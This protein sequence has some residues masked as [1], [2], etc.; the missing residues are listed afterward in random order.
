MT[1]REW[2]CGGGKKLDNLL[3]TL[4]SNFESQVHWFPHGDQDNIIFGVSLLSTW[5]H[6]T[7]PAGRQTQMTNWV[8]WVRDLWRDSDPYLEDFA[9]FSQVMQKMSGDMDWKLNAAV[10]CMTDSLPGANELVRVYVDWVQ[11]NWRAAGLRLQDDRN[12]YEIAWSRLW[13]RLKIKIHTFTPKNGMFDRI[14]ELSD[15]A[16][17][18]EVMS[19]IL[20]MSWRSSP[21]SARGISSITVVARS[22]LF[23]RG[24]HKAKLMPTVRRLTWVMILKD[25][26]MVS[27]WYIFYCQ[28]GQFYSICL[29]TLP[30]SVWNAS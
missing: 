9:D 5:N 1:H 17:D 2:Y 24:G 11:A 8:E 29:G 4:Q 16:A 13:P 28:T 25:F 26:F 15:C 6:Q 3:N 12:L 10:Q 19:L 22:W 7:D 27:T 14:E 18:S 20:L 23:F 21:Q 30:W